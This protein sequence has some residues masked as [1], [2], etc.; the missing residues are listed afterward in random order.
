MSYKAIISG[1]LLLLAMPA[2]SSAASSQ[3]FDGTMSGTIICHSG[4]AKFKIPLEITLFAGQMNIEGPSVPITKTLIFDSTTP[5]QTSTGGDLN[6]SEFDGLFG[7]TYKGNIND[8]D[9][10][11]GFIASQFSDDCLYVATIKVKRVA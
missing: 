2:V 11:T 8:M 6:Y 7:G 9:S 4:E 10:I 1:I 3:V 5:N